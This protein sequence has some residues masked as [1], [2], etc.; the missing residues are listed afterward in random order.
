[1]AKRAA[2]D[3][4]VRGFIAAVFPDAPELAL[5]AF[6]EE[7][8]LKTATELLRGHQQ[9]EQERDRLQRILEIERGYL[10]RLAIC[11]DHRGKHDG[12][13]IVCQAEKRTADEYRERMQQAEQV[14]ETEREW[15]VIAD[16]QASGLFMQSFERGQRVATLT[17]ALKDYGQHPASCPKGVGIGYYKPP[18]NAVCNCGIDAALTGAQAK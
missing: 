13:C 4:T 5:L 6:D 8:V 15:R 9:A 14:L 1:M 16:K 18:A 2:T 11:P 10:E 3:Q 17:Q 7:H 12:T